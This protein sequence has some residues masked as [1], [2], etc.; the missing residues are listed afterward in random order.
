MTMALNIACLVRES[1]KQHPD[2]PALLFDGGSMTF[3]EVDALSDRLA[4]GLRASGFAPG[5]AIGMQ[6]PNLPQFVIA[7]FGILKAGCVAVPM[8]V[9]LQAPEIAFQLGDSGAK[10]LITWA[11]TADTAAKAAEA[12][13][14]DHLYVVGTPGTPTTEVGEP[15]EALIAA[16]DPNAP[17]PFE[18]C[19]PG[20][21]AVLIYTSGTTGTPKGA[22]LTHFQLLLNADTPGRL[23]GIRD[24][25]VVLVALPL[26][27]VF[28]LSSQ[29]NVCMRFGATMS[30]MPRFDPGRAVEVIRRDGVT[31]FEGV[32]TMYIA[33]LHQPDVAPEDVAT[34]R[35]GVSGGA[36]LPA[37][38]LDAFERRFGIVI[39]E[40]Y[41]LTESASTTT[42]N[43]SAEERKVYSVG[44]PIWGVDLQVWGE[45]DRVLPTGTEH[46]GEVV[47]R[48]VNVMKGYYNNPEATR[49]AFTR[50]WM[51]T[52]DLGYLDED[53]YLFIVDRKKDLIIRGGYNVYP[54]EVEEAL[55]SHPDIAEAA[56]IGVPDE[57][58]GEEVKAFVVPKPGAA[59]TADDVIALARERVAAYK[60]PRVVELRSEMA[61]GPTGKILKTEL[62]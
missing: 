17:A 5:D 33:L 47:I 58:L 26:F 37:E 20:D 35:I 48:G 32:P 25:D 23:F 49:A 9:L 30:L 11:G 40:G 21:T 46:V 54:R 12:A 44:K 8:N 43:V 52:G 62:R 14:V 3:G 61:H 27:H 16:A 22:E 50:G 1:A 13:D 7:Y 41:G 60:Y 51:R 31:V 55:Y 18:Q 6:L 19:D 36:S 28:G 57:H 10:A 45:D 24:D 56:V 38:V 29:L 4:A 39:L 59:L 34:L 53:G 15:F 42:F 2:K